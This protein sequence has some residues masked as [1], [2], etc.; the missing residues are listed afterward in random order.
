MTS[1][2]WPPEKTGS[3]PKTSQKL[4]NNLNQRGGPV[5]VVIERSFW[6]QCRERMNWRDTRLLRML[7]L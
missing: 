2:I 7:L 5:I 3:Y 1:L 4:P 6:W